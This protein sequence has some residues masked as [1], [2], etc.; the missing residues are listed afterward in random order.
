MV[1]ANTLRAAAASVRRMIEDGRYD[2]EPCLTGA[3]AQWQFAARDGNHTV[4]IRPVRMDNPPRTAETVPFDLAVDVDGESCPVGWC[5]SDPWHDL[6][7]A[8]YSLTPVALSVS[9]EYNGVAGTSRFSTA[10]R[11][12]D[13][14]CLLGIGVTMP[15]ARWSTVVGRAAEALAFAV[16]AAVPWVRQDTLSIIVNQFV[17]QAVPEH[18]ALHA[19][20]HVDDL[21]VHVQREIDGFAGTV[22]MFP[23]RQAIVLREPAPEAVQPVSIPAPRLG[24]MK[25]S[26][27]L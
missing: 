11:L 13:V 5:P 25:R 4:A 16:G 17:E 9:H 2:R 3:C 10:L 22:R 19:G 21:L 23:V 14:E 24:E 15:D 18:R 8:A 20:Y 6:R 1:R 27:E 26:L 12:W 7:E